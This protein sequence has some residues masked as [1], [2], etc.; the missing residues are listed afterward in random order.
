[1]SDA[2]NYS[3]LGA[4]SEIKTLDQSKR[5]GDIEHACLAKK[6]IASKA[7]LIVLRETRLITLGS[8]VSIVI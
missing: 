5:L 4:K 6:Q 3:S 7:L 1:M 8:L 2:N